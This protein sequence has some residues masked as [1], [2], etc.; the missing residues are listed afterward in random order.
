MR[1]VASLGVVEKKRA[2]RRGPATRALSA[3]LRK[4][5]E[6]Q[7]L[8]QAEL[9]ERAGLDVSYVSQ[10]ERGLRDPSLSSLRAIAA[11]VGLNVAE[12]LVEGDPPAGD[13]P[14]VRAIVQ[15]LKA[16]ASDQLDE[17]LVVVRAIRRVAHRATPEMS[18]PKD[19]SAPG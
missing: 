11:A 12:L 4:I 15:E 17:V 6:E 9:A 8:T 16:F 10:M 14:L 18:A 3:R 5:R 13:P 1:P 7:R 2:K 19:P